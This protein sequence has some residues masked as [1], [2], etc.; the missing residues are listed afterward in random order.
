[1]KSYTQKRL[2]ITFILAGADSVFPGTN[3]NTLVLADNFRA[4]VRAQAVARLS[5]KAELRVYGMLPADMDALTI[6][7]SQAPV[8]LDN[9]VIVE[10]D[11]GDGYVKVFEGTMIEAQPNYQSL[12]DVSFDVLAMTGYY[13]K[14]NPVPPTSYQAATDIDTVASYLAEQMGFSYTNGGATGVF[15]EG[16][17]FWGTYWDQLAQACQATSNDFY[18]FGDR[19]FL[20]AAGRPLNDQPAVVLTPDTGLIGYPMFERSGLRV[21]AIFDPALSCGVPIDISGSVPAATGR[22]YPYQLHYALD[23]RMPRGQWAASMMCNKVF[24]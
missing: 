24:T 10:A 5:T 9:I 21:N 16:S 12:P 11:N 20:T 23:A 18:V 3:S 13:Q 8:V 2:R 7:W 17:Y 19:L 15:A 1:M 14:I 22:W 4:S 6:T